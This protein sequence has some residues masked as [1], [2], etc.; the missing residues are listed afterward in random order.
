M[1]RI[2]GV[3]WKKSLGLFIDSLERDLVQWVEHSKNQEDGESKFDEELFCPAYDE[4]LDAGKKMYFS[5]SELCNCLPI[6]FSIFFNALFLHSSSV[7]KKAKK[8]TE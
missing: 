3:A 7:F 5:F 8:S 6:E 4:A 2:N 1:D